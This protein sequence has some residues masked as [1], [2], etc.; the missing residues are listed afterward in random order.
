MGS[1]TQIG[2]SIGLFEQS[3]IRTYFA[4]LVFEPVDFD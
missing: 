2:C 3:T 1:G 4:Q